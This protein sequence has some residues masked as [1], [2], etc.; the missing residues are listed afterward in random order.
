M[1]VL[2]GHRGAAPGVL[3][4]DGPLAGDQVDAGPTALAQEDAVQVAAVDHPVRVAVAALEV[5]QV[6]PGQLAAVHVFHD[7]RLGQ[8]TELVGLVEQSVLVED[9][10]AVGGDL[11][12][13]AHFPELRRALEHAHAKT[14]PEQRVGGAEPADA[15]ADD[16][17]VRL[18]GRDA[19][20]R[21]H[22]VLLHEGWSRPGQSQAGKSGAWA[23][24]G[25]ATPSAPRPQ[26]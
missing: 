21:G 25:V 6:E 24:S 10:G 26:R 5:E 1:A 19:V 7:H 12:L 11:H 20:L 16:D 14:G 15:A 13:G 9:A 3:E 23:C 4:A 18:F 2:E 8:H 17:D 22:V